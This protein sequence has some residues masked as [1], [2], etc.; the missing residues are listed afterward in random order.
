VTEGR[1]LVGFHVKEETMLWAGDDS[2]D[3]AP[4]VRLRSRVD[5]FESQQHG[6]V[7]IKE[8]LIPINWSRDA[9]HGFSSFQR[10]DVPSSVLESRSWMSSCHD[11]QLQSRR[12]LQGGPSLLGDSGCPTRSTPSPPIYT[13][14]GPSC[15]YQASSTPC[16]FP[17]ESCLDHL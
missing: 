5:A 8:P 10:R 14:M 13:I 12:G 9:L 7:L 1:I 16:S 4:G 17:T 2:L 6:E 11:R 3:E 15:P